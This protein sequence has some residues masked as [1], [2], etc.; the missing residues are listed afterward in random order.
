MSG[1]ANSGAGAELS[2]QSIDKLVRVFA[3]EI[4]LP[5]TRQYASARKVWNRAVNKY[6]AIIARCA[7]RDDVIRAVEFA[8]RNRLLTAVRSG[9]HSFAGYGVC[10]GGLVIDLSLMKSARLQPR[11]ATITIGPGIAGGELDYMAQAFKMAVPLGSCPSTGVAGYALGG[12]ESS[13]TP[14]FGFA[15]DSISAVELVTADAQVVTARE[16]ENE[17]LFWAVRGAGANFG[18]ATALEFRLHP[19]EKVYSGH[20]RYP[21]RQARKVLRFID[22]YAPTIPDE[23]YLLAA[24]LPHPGERMLDVAVLWPGDEKR[25]ARILRPL[26]SFLKPFADT[27]KTKEY[28]D[29]QRGGSD[30]PGDGDYASC[31]RGGQCERLTSDAIEVIVE[32]AE[33]APTESSGITLIYWHGPWSSGK[34]D[35]AFGF[36][37]T[38]FEYWI[39]SYWKLK[40]EARKAV[41]WVE[42]FF[43][44]MQPHSS[45][46]VYV[47][48][49]EEEGDLRAKAAYGDNYERLSRIKR[50]FDP[51]NFFRVNQNIRPAAVHLN[52][53]G[54][55]GAKHGP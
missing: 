10:D 17:D 18:I 24:V 48:D 15:C 40:S 50:K 52:H 29:E 36:R 22:E 37:C 28:L 53:Q 8:R 7:H 4:I 11:S 34:H 9:G 47:N 26:R 35:N 33:S 44:A 25:G 54:R 51:D 13:L 32:Q 45:G 30:T 20:L 39:H 16:G 3:G 41:S 46:A 19:I 38:G 43:G 21:I 23:L 27:I 55:A 6:P 5:G 31:R 1:L 49:L 14:K 42:Q 12:G 2:R